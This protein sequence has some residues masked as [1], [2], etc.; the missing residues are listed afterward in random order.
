MHSLEWLGIICT[1]LRHYRIQLGPLKQQKNFGFFNRKEK[2]ITT[3]FTEFRTA[4]T[5]R[6]ACDVPGELGECSKHQST[7]KSSKNW[8]KHAPKCKLSRC[9]NLLWEWKCLNVLYSFMKIW[10]SR[11]GR[12]NFLKHQEDQM[13]DSKVDGVEGGWLEGNFDED[14]EDGFCSINCALSSSPAKK[15]ACPIPNHETRRPLCLG[16]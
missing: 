7:R 5:F 15:C 6:D 2:S 9:N 11:D 3:N 16:T 12:D 13:A 1:S 14:D 8:T 10:E 4:I